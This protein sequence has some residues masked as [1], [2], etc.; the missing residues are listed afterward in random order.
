MKMPFLGQP[1]PV[2]RAAARKEFPE[3]MATRSNGASLLSRIRDHYG[4]LR[5]AERRLADLIL[6]F[7]GEIAGYSATELAEMAE[8]ISETRRTAREKHGWIMDTYLIRRPATE[9][10]EGPA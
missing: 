7:P 10:E 8:T 5:P 9:A 4:E 1:L 2:N 3:E 6:S